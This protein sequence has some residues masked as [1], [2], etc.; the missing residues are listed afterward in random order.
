MK[1]LNWLLACILLVACGDDEGELEGD[2]LRNSLVGKWD[3]YISI[4]PDGGTHNFPNDILLNYEHGFQLN[5][6]GTYNPRYLDSEDPPT[7]YTSDIEHHWELV[8]E[9]KIVFGDYDS[10]GEIKGFIYEIVQLKNDELWIGTGLEYR[11]KKA[12]D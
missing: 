1:K 11:L 12:T 10:A 8:D 5:A 4:G 3:A 2:T 9:N 7:F 6:D